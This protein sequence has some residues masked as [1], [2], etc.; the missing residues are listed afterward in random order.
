MKTSVTTLAIVLLFASLA[1]LPTGVRAQIVFDKT[2]HDFGEIRE[3]DKPTHTFEFRNT[4]QKPVKLTSVR[5]SCGCTT[6][7][8]TT[9]EV[10]PG[11]RGSIDVAYSSKGRVGKFTKSITVRHDAGG[12][13]I[14]LTIKGDVRPNPQLTEINYLKTTGSLAIEQPKLSLGNISSD[15]KKTLTFYVK[16]VGMKPITLKK[17]VKADPYY[18]FEPKLFTLDPREET[19]IEIVIDGAKMK[20][21]DLPNNAP[22]DDVITFYTE[23]AEDSE[24][25]IRIN[26]KFLRIYSEEERKAMPFIEFEAE[27]FDGGTIISGEKLT[28]QF[29]FT[30]KGG[31]PLKI[32]RV[33]ASCGCTATAPSQEELQP[34]ESAYVEA[35]FDSRGRSGKQHKTIMV[36]SNDPVN[37]N[38]VLHLRV[39][40]DRDP[41]GSG[42]APLNPGGGGF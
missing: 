4:L 25:S 21:V 10:G 33:K 8:Y 16:N 3:G 30:N 26:G 13:P 37:P 18:S 22:I 19:Q 35:T 5:A 28:H 27:E 32:E 34:G 7:Q 17:D 15:E 20:A 42:S 9:D 41:F 38:I 31:Q 2:L 12:T 36:K 29:K 1:A 23:E 40:V 14:T 11:E 6:P 24:K 39:E